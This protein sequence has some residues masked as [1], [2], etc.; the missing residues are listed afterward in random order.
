MFIQLFGSILRLRNILTAFDEFADNEILSERDYQDYQSIYLDDHGDLRR[1][2]D[3]EKSP[4]STTSSSR[5]E[6]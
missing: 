6:P 4:S 2:A 3:S 5:V 1:D